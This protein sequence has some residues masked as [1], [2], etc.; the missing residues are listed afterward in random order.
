MQDV[1]F[2]PMLRVALTTVTIW[3]VFIGIAL[4]LG[5]IYGAKVGTIAALAELGAL[6]AA[7]TWATW[8]LN[9]YPDATLQVFTRWPFVRIVRE[10]DN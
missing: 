7:C 2:Q 6:I 1:R 4:G 3:A 5:L 10:P 9:L 8:L